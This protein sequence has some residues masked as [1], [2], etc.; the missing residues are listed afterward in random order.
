ME[1]AGR[2]EGRLEEEVAQLTEEISLMRPLQRKLD[3]VQYEG[4]TNIGNKRVF[5]HCGQ[6]VQGVHGV[7]GVHT[8][9]IE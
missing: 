2:S 4:R 7:H 8:A 5:G 9:Y 1:V 3:K 6:G